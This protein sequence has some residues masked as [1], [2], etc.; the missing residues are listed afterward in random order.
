MNT[1]INITG[2]KTIRTDSNHTLLFNGKTVQIR[3]NQSSNA[4]LPKTYTLPTIPSEY[5]CHKVIA[6]VASTISDNGEHYGLIKALADGT[7]Q[8]VLS[9]STYSSSGGMTV[10]GTLEYT[11]N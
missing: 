10:H 6:T 7:L 5:R 1:Q 8:L 9:K 11:I 4:G 2:F 3:I